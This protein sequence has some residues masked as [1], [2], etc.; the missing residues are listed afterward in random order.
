M[1]EKALANFFPEI[2][3]EYIWELAPSEYG[4]QTYFSVLNGSKTVKVK[5]RVLTDD[6]KFSIRYPTL[7]N[8]FLDVANTSNCKDEKNQSLQ[9][10][11]IEQS[12]G[13]VS[14]VF[15]SNHSSATSISGNHQKYNIATTNCKLLFSIEYQ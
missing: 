1:K 14:C 13:V 4:S 5:Y 9:G 11:Q 3:K 8:G 6:C 15:S 2:G 7:C 10:S 12:L